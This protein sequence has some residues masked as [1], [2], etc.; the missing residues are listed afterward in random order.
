MAPSSPGPKIVVVGGGIAG[1]SAAA[2]LCRHPLRPEVTVVEA[3]ATLAHHT[4]G[5]SAALYI[6]N[7]S[8]GP[9]RVLT[10]ASGPYLR[11]PPADLVDGPLLQRRGVLSV[12]L[13]G[14]EEAFA[15]SLADGQLV[16]PAISEIEITEA[17]E[18]FP[19]LRGDR[20]T[21]AMFEPDAS[22][23][24]VSALHQSFVRGVIRDGG[25]ISTTTVAERLTWSGTGWAIATSDGELTADLVINA[26]GAWGDR[27]AERAG[28]EPIGL[29][30]LRRTAFMINRPAEVPARA[31]LA[32]EVGH[33]RWYL[34]PDGDQILCSPA[35]ETPSEP[36]DARP[37]EIDI[38]RAI[39]DI[40]D[41][42]TL[43]IRSIRSSWA[44]L[45]TFSPDRTMVFGP[46]PA[47]PG[48][49]WAVG[50]GGAGIQ[51]S[52]GAGQLVADLALDGEPG[53][54]FSTEATGL[55]FDPA[56]LSPARFR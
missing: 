4:T 8:T 51:T 37:E 23:I 1:V 2:A 28:V 13:P 33:Q 11:Q 18:R 15:D 48:F 36:C 17:V 22:D 3:E 16:N 25:T 21:R 9:N 50:Q 54:Q 47:V 41:T 35:D 44:G 5:R 12:A 45:R 27:V 55:P 14:Q 20:I 53:P 46:D 40:N 24:D 49:V 19:V 10:K 42:T 38:A 32:T 39:D 29:R 43:A 52:P 7:Y 34:K 6:E 26:G 56:D 31:P 30:P